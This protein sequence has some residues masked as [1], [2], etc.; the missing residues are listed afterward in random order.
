[1][2]SKFTWF[3]KLTTT[4]AKVPE[5]QRGAL[6]WAL[7]QYGTY[8]TEPTLEYPLDAIFESLR[9]DIDNSKRSIQGGQKGGRNTPKVGRGT[10]EPP[11]CVKTQPPLFKS[12]TPPALM[13]KRPQGGGLVRSLRGV[14]K[15]SNPNQSKPYQTKPIK[16]ERR[17]RRHASCLRPSMRSELTAG[18]KVTTSMPKHSSLSTNRRAGSS[19]SPA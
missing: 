7:V 9:E 2:E 17:L 1:M 10:H 13:M 14:T 15:T 8:G 11:P 18:R 12:L 4:V 16:R 6:L 5:E 3:P 19:A